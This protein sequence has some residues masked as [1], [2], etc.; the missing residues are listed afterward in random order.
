MVP[1]LQK[2][3]PSTGSVFFR[4]NAPFRPEEFEFLRSAGIDIKPVEP[5]ENMRWCLELRHPRHGKAALVCLKEQR[6]PP[7]DLIDIS[8]GLS[9]SER[10]A[11]KGVGNMLNIRVSATRKHVLRDRKSMLWYMRQVLGKDGVVGVDH[12]SQLFWPPG[13]LDEELAHDADLDISAVHCLHCITDSSMDTPED[14]RTCTWVHSHGLAELGAFDFDV[15]RP[16]RDIVSGAAGDVLRAIA[17][18]IVE[19]ELS[20]DTPAWEFSYPMQLL[21]TV[22]ADEFDRS[23]P[24]SERD[25]REPEGH[26]DNR[27][28]I[29]NPVKKGL[30]RLKSAVRANRFLQ[31]EIDG[32]VFRFSKPAT[33]LMADRAKKTLSV[34]ERL[35]DEFA[36]FI[37]EEPWKFGVMAKIGYAT[38]SKEGGQEHLWFS[39]QGV[40]KDTIDATL[41]NKPF[42]IARMNPGDRGQHPIEQLTDWTI[43]TPI[44]HVTPSDMIAARLI[45]SQR[46][47]IRAFM[48]EVEECERA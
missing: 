20:R 39:V 37:G 16:S 42:D 14:E 2:E 43:Q 31:G 24:A 34:L 12:D 32:C 38:D 18:A 41:L 47:K 21:R 17:F 25:C 10:E 23:A 3:N 48:R 1:W 45:R 9:A 7:A 4:G 22:P 29:C 40:R 30:L 11:A 28:V 13:R 33:D 27:A 36:E 6:M 15:I 46:D 8:A 44:G 19:G 26:T 35:M 5:N